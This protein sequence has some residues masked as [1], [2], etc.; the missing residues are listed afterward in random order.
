MARPRFTIPVL[1]ALTCLLGGLLVVQRERIPESFSLSRSVPFEKLSK[2]ARCADG[3]FA[4]VFDSNKRIARVGADGALLYLVPARNDPEKGFF[5]ANEITFDP[6]GRLYVASTYIDTGTLTVNREAVV[7]FSPEGRPEAV[8]YLID[9]SPDQ[10]TDNIGLIRSLQWTPDGLRFCVTRAEGIHTL[11]VNPED[12]AKVDETVTPLAGEQDNVIYAAVSAD[13]REMAYSTAATEIYAAVPGEAPAKRYDGRDLPDE[14]FSIP[15]DLHYLG[16]EL[17]FSDLGRDAIMRLTAKNSAEPLFNKDIAWSHGYEDAFYECKSFQISDGDLTLPNHGKVVHFRTR[18]PAAI[19]TLDRAQ[20]NAALW[21]KRAFL[22]MQLALFAVFALT[23]IILA[24]RHASPDGRRL[25]KQVALV[26]LMLGTAVGITTYMIFNNMN[27]RLAEEARNNLRGFLAVGRIVVDVEAV[28]RIQHVKDYMNADYQSVLKQL[29]QTI[30]REGAIDPSTYSGVY[31]VFGDKLSALAYHDGLRGIFY[32]YDYQYG[33]SI[34]AQVAASGQPY[35][36]EIVDI[37]GV[38]L[39]GV[40]PLVNS[41][42]VTV[43]LLEVGVDQSAQ[44]EANR[45]LFKS[46]LMD[47]AMVLFVLLFI[48]FEIGFFSSHVMDRADRADAAAWQ[49]YDEGALRFV[50]FLAI[51]GVFLSASFLPLYIK[52][53]APA[54]GRFPDLIIGLPM[55]IETLCGAV[56]ALL[57]GHV[58]I[59]AGIKTDV[60]LGCLVIMAG[61]VATGLAP[62]FNWLIAG[63]VLVGMGMG[64]LMIAFRTYFLIEKHDGKKE[65]GIIALTAG[66]IAGINTGS[67]SGGMLAARVGMKPVFLIQAALLVLAA[68]AAL[69]LVRNRRRATLPADP[70]AGPALSPWVFLRARAVWSFFVFVFLP[71]TTCGLFLGFLFPL[72]AEAQGCSINEISLAFMLFGAASVYLGPALT[73]LTTVLFGARRA[74]PIGALIMTGALL[75]FAIFQSLAAAYVT[76]ILFGLTESMVFNQGLSFYSSLPSVR[77]FGEDKAMGVYNVFESGGE[78]LGPMA[79][80]LAASLSLGIGIAAIAA[81]LGTCALAFW[82]LGPRSGGDRS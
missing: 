66:V 45:A 64:L 73:R 52:A 15:S 20:G 30:T 67:V 32:P 59:R 46:T 1:F 61:M 29:C 26:A 80:G 60:V 17:C 39:N 34:Y 53:L 75:L 27:R 28:D 82:A 25:A 49:R 12:G 42:G 18:A 11:L 54:I 55:V 4:V 74:M 44:R 16:G 56:I 63:R 3:S 47:L 9:H 36:G 57:Y 10:Y 71:V 23:L 69:V 58:R 79:F 50:S 5:F 21:I 41:N 2:A 76:I 6:A 51:T 38:W 72:F 22:W 68:A 77:R 43:G 70:A 33:K 14:I 19:H 37:Y 13:G 40:V 35:V 81:A 78:A 65:S 31:K 62:T 7:R 24:I 8:L 48:F